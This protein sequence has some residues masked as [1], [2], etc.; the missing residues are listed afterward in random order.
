MTFTN[1]DEADPVA[2]RIHNAFAGLSNRYRDADDQETADVAY[3][4]AQYDRLKTT[5]GFSESVERAQK[6]Y[7]RYVLCGAELPM[8][9]TEDKNR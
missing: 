1:Y 7:L 8:I 6:L 3:I 2:A 4:L 9:P 5:L